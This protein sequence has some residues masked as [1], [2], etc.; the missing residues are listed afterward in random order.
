MVIP[1]PLGG[2]FQMA[3]GW[4]GGTGSTGGEDASKPFD[5]IDTIIV[6]LGLVLIL[7]VLLR[8]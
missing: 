1:P 8:R 2:V 7:L 5:S 4:L 6:G 3:R